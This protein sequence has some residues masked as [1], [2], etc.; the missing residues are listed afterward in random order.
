MR[1]ILVISNNKKIDGFCTRLNED[2]LNRITVRNISDLEKSRED[3]FSVILID[4]DIVKDEGRGFIERISAHFKNSKVIPLVSEE[5]VS[6]AIK[7]L[8]CSNDEVVTVPCCA[9]YFFS[10]IRNCD[11]P[12]KTVIQD[13]KENP[14]LNTFIGVSDSMITLKEK[15]VAVAKNDVPVLILG[16]TG[17]G[18]S[19]I[20]KFIHALSSR[21]KMKFV[22]ENIA[23]IQESVLEGE[24]FGT[25]NGAFTGALTKK[26]LIEYANKGTLF[27]DEISCIENS[28]QA[29]LLD[30]LESGEYRAVGDVE[31]RK[32]D[33]RLITA[34]NTPIDELKNNKK[35]RSDL[36]Y[37]I[38]GIQLYVPQ[39]KERREDICVLAIH[40]LENYIASSGVIKK[41][42]GDAL[43]KLQDHDW[44][45]NVRELKRCIECAYFM[46]SDVTITA[47]DISFVS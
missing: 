46:S 24:L 13:S 17:V 19:Y 21:S 36:Y 16:A 35:F 23:A 22:S 38:S 20:A 12:Q 30:V 39:L 34:T 9:E 25:K 27:L 45:G 4:F 41:L 31:K 15:I 29:K 40:F 2:G 3:V 18:K 5:T 6:S 11:Y 37:R 47:R 28:I 43:N 26:G 10:C 32:S 42:R 44:P 1:N 14:I 33:M 7:M 8:H